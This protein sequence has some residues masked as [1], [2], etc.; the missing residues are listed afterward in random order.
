[1]VLGHDL[2]GQ[3]YAVA[4]KGHQ[5]RGEAHVH[6]DIIGHST[7]IARWCS[8]EIDGVLDFIVLH[9]PLGVSQGIFII[10]LVECGRL[11]APRLNRS[12]SIASGQP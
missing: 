12:R 8:G 1:M 11:A 4:R 5:G 10:C 3:F 2:Q 7:V 6:I 9:M